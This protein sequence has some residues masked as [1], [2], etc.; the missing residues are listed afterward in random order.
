MA[1]A[2]HSLKSLADLCTSVTLDLAIKLV[3]EATA[4]TD[5]HIDPNPNL[6]LISAHAPSSVMGE[7]SMHNAYALWLFGRALLGTVTSRSPEP[8]PQCPSLVVSIAS[9]HSRLAS[10]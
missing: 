10:P 2:C 1:S 5:A 3:T 8:S 6:G 9:H 7:P 4:R